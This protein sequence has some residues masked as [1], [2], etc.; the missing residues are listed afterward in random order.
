MAALK[1]VVAAL[2]MVPVVEA[3]NIPFFPQF[4][5]E[6]GVVTPN[7]VM[8]QSATAMLD[9]LARLEAALRPLRGAPGGLSRRRGAALLDGAAAETA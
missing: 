5:G 3:V 1:P 7:D 4:L 6:G 9:E 2:R 8:T